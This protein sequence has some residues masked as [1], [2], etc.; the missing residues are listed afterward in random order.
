MVVR[1]ALLPVT[2]LLCFALPGSADVARTADGFYELKN[3]KGNFSIKVT[4]WGATLVSVVVPDCHGDLT[5]VV[6]GY[7]T[8]A[9]YAKGAAA[10]S[11]IG[12]VAN[13]IANARFVLDG[14]TYRLFRNDGNNTIH[15]GHRGFNKVIWTVKEHVQYGDSPYITYYRSFDGEQGFP[16][17]LDV[18]VTYR[19]SDPYDLSIHMNATATSKATP[20]NLVNHAYWNLAGHGSGDVLEHELQMFASQYTPVDGYMIPTGQVAP[21]AGT[22]DVSRE[23]YKCFEEKE[24]QTESKR[25]ETFGKVIFGKETIQETWS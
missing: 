7:D 11:T 25:N 2:L 13:R 6:L 12:R 8:V 16:G 18:Y 22:N 15:G 14:K 9:G 17:Y 1:A 23:Y 10:G 5:D 4:N 3:K 21:V 19:L 20:V 24:Y